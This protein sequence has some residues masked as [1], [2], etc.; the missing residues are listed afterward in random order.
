VFLPRGKEQAG[1]DLT[2]AL[3]ALAANALIFYAPLCDP[4]V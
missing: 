2:P 4:D 3:L 1:F